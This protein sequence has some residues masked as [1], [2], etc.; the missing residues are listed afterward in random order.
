MDWGLISAWAGVVAGVIAANGAT[1]RWL[2]DRRDDRRVRGEGRIG[3]IER[4]FYEFKANLPL[5]YV[6]RED[7]IRFIATIDAKLDSMRDELRDDIGAV[8]EQLYAGRD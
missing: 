4:A 6:R 3:Q 2:M 8:K 7:W 5:E 1:M